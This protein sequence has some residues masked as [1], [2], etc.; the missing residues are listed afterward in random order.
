MRVLLLSLQIFVFLC[1]GLQASAET[2]ERTF[3][4]VINFSLFDMQYEEADNS[5]PEEIDQL[6]QEAIDE[7]YDYR[8]TRKVHTF[9]GTR[10]NSVTLDFAEELIRSIDEHPVVSSFA[11]SKYDPE[12]RGIGFCFGRAAYAHIALMEMGV[13]KDA[14]KKA[15]AV[16][17]MK[18]GGNNW[19]WHVTTLVLAKNGQWV[20]IDNVPGG[21][22]LEVSEWIKYFKRWSTDQKLRLYISNPKKFTPSP[23][24]YERNSLGLDTDKDND[25]YNGYFKD[26]MKWFR[27]NNVQTAFDLPEPE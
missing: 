22:V 18:N 7:L 10:A 26:L 27:K 5:T 4:K 20:A 19:G 25:W 8:V 3:A 9:K 17:H 2:T 16:G 15:W 13:N 12:D 1:L 24:T 6:N 21:Q 14:V 23:G 11:Y